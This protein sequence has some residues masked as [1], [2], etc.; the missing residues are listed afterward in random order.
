MGSAMVRVELG[1]GPMFEPNT[2]VESGKNTS[3]HCMV[4]FLVVVSHCQKTPA[5]AWGSAWY[6]MPRVRGPKSGAVR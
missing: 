1:L 3:V 4:L 6:H 2:L 5:L